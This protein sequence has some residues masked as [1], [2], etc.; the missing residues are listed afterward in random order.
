MQPA[1]ASA[2]N[3]VRFRGLPLKCAGCG[4]DDLISIKLGAEVVRSET[5]LLVARGAAPKAWCSKC[6][7]WS[8]SDAG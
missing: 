5:G 6:W 3:I 2:P 4:S 7:T 8:R 1:V